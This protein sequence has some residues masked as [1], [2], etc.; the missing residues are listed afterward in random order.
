MGHP[1]Q[2]NPIRP[3]SRGGA[4]RTARHIAAVLCC[5]CAALF[6]ELETR[7]FFFL[8]VFPVVLLLLSNI[9]SEIS[10]SCS[11]TQACI[12]NP[13]CTPVSYQPTDYVSNSGLL[14]RGLRSSRF[15]Q[16]PIAS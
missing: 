3:T 15:F 4:R 14:F 9:D 2:S 16:H 7:L 11:V 6:L 10:S 13:V 12:Q 8:S 1:S 5:I